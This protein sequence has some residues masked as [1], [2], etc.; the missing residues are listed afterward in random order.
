MGVFALNSE[1]RDKEELV[2]YMLMGK[3][4]TQ[5]WE[6]SERLFLEEDL[7]CVTGQTEQTAPMCETD[8]LSHPDQ[9]QMTNARHVL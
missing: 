6:I 4:R 5:M 9:A 1:L 8:D 7:D 3:G 2:I